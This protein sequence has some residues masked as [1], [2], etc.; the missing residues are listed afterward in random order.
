MT[1]KEITEHLNHEL[2]KHILNG[3]GNYWAKEVTFDY[4][5]EGSCRVDYMLYKPVN[6]LSVDGL[7]KGIF[8]CYEIKSCV[9]D[10][11]S[12]H[13]LNFIGEQNYLVMMKD[14]YD[15]L[16][17]RKMNT[18][19]SR[20]VGI[21]VYDSGKFSAAKCSYKTYRTKSMVEMLFAMLRSRQ[22]E[23]RKDNGNDE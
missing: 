16:K 8:I 7:E 15:T 23:N 3:K 17:E 6:Q 20:N 13:G 21:L 14:T 10:F 5:K 11:N 12:G 1:R 2:E 4:G 19:V 18:K 22:A 9:E